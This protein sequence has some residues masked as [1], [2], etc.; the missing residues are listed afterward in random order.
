MA[1]ARPTITTDVPGCRETVVPGATGWLVPARDA[2]ALAHAMLAAA[3]RPER[4]E[5]MGLA[6]RELA[7]SHFDVRQV[8][9]LVLQGMGLWRGRDQA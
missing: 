5:A 1:M 9:A 8:N 7:G 3:E 2:E 4:L 6:A